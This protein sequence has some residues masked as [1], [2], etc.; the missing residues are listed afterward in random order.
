MG[1]DG[2]LG[3]GEE[4]EGG[5]AG[6]RMGDVLGGVVTLDVTVGG[7]R[8]KCVC[9]RESCKVKIDQHEPQETKKYSSNQ[10]EPH[11]PKSIPLVIKVNQRNQRV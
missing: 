8:C 3:E 5:G 7:A 6:L 2:D 11:G 10:S 1:S 4:E 9:E